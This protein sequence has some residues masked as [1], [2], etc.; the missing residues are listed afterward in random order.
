[1]AA[2]GARED[3]DAFACVA[4]LP[5]IRGLVSLVDAG[6]DGAYGHAH[7]A[8]AAGLVGDERPRRTTRQHQAVPRHRLLARARHG[9]ARNETREGGRSRAA[10]VETEAERVSES[11]R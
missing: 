6:I 10:D 7:R 3:R 11:V 5:A 1:M 4:H 9:H 2:A 8:D